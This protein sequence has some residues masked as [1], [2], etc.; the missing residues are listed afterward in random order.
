MNITVDFLQN[1]ASDTEICNHLRAC[2]VDFSPPL[3]SR[4]EIGDYAK[5][6]VR[7]AVRFEA[8]S[9]NTLV[10]LVAAYCNDRDTGDAYITSVSVLKAWARKGIASRLVE[11][12][13][14]HASR[15]GMRRVRLQVEKNNMTAIKLYE[16]FGF[17]AAAPNPPFINMD[18]ILEIR[19]R[20]DEK[21]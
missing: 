19:G 5:K 4:I 20:H 7:N 12:A 13:V 16:K 17:V 11:Q 1:K 15:S 9:E 6:I 18:L 10:G 14:E 8:W 21:A 3:S 2:D